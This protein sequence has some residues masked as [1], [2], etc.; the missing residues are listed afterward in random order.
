MALLEEIAMF[1]ELEPEAADNETLVADSRLGLAVLVEVLEL[2]NGVALFKGIGLPDEH[3]VVGPVDIPIWL[4]PSQQ[5]QSPGFCVGLM[6]PLLRKMLP[7]QQNPIEVWQEGL[8]EACESA[9]NAAT[10]GI[11]DMLLGFGGLV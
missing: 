1:T 5:V 11:F 3:F 8:V 9:R 6:S 10:R 4:L 2:D 7:L